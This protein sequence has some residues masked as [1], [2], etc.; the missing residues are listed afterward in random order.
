LDTIA[1]PTTK[2]TT[3]TTIGTTDT[4]DTTAN[5]TATATADLDWLQLTNNVFQYLEDHGLDG[6]M[7]H[8]DGSND[9]DRICFAK[10]E[11]EVLR[12]IAV[13]D[14]RFYR[15]LRSIF[16]YNDRIRAFVEEHEFAHRIVVGVHVRTGNGEK[17]DFELK[18]RKIN[19]QDTVLKQMAGTIHKLIESIA[20]ARPSPR[21]VIAPLVF[22]A[23]DEESVVNVLAG[24]LE[25]LGAEVI[26]FPQEYM[27]SGRGVTYAKSDFASD[28]ECLEG[29]ISQVID[30]MLLGMADAIVA[31]RYSSFTQSLPLMTLF[32][33]SIRAQQK[34]G[35]RQGIQQR[36]IF[37]SSE[38][39]AN[40]RDDD[41]RF[42][43]RLFCEADGSGVSMKCFDDYVDWALNDKP[44]VVGSDFSLGRVRYQIEIRATC[45]SHNDDA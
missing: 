25:E 16:R 2:T 15:Q 10:K 11:R 23:T 7:K 31:A 3:T 41:P 45:V 40:H 34:D 4:T 36:N 14:E 28:D 30:S 24:P 38:K 1:T 32:S 17:T 33:D 42:A 27:E 35:W 13:A 18:K 39:G 29:W 44:L 5:T 37:R 26:H 9:Q 21:V 19:Q 20:R 12:E 22:V 43:N 6:L 8:T